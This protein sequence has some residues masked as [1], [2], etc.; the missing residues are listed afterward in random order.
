M[1]DSLNLASN[2]PPMLTGWKPVWF[3]STTLPWPEPIEPT[4][5]KDL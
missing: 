5:E 1:T 3:L 4:E 2:D